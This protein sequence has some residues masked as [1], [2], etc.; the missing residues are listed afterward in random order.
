MIKSV[1]EGSNP[2]G[3][4]PLVFIKM[5]PVWSGYC[6]L[7]LTD[8][9]KKKDLFQVPFVHFKVQNQLFLMC[10]NIIC[11]NLIIYY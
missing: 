9:P 8:S 11:T 1:V 3:K 6:V 2:K 10:Y 5:D 4:T 7:V